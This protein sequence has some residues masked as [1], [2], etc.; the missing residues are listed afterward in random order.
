MAKAT[1]TAPGFWTTKIFL[2]PAGRAAYLK[3]DRRFRPRAQGGLGAAGTKRRIV[4]VALLLLDRI[5]NQRGHWD[6]DQF[7]KN[8]G[9]L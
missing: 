2:T 9:Q 1:K 5:A 4:N 7:E 3:L 8:L 6:L